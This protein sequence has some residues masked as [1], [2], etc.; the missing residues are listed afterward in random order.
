MRRLAVVFGCLA[1]A[2]AAC[3]GDSS[4]GG[5][6][7]QFISQGDAIC[8]DTIATVNS[9]GSGTDTATLQKASDAWAQTFQKLDTLAVPK[10]TEA[11]ALEFK[12]NVHN[13]A[14]TADE[15]YQASLDGGSSQR[16]QKAVQDLAAAKKQAGKTAQDYG[17]KVCSQ[18]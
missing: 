10:D 18:L 1:V 9:V 8:R 16:V 12:A 15:A 2:L 14:L 4:A 13:A 17:F 7:G 5:A 3:G 11:K 6:K